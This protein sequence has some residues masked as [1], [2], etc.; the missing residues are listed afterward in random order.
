MARCGEF[1]LLLLLKRSLDPPAMLQPGDSELPG[2][3]QYGNVTSSC[4]RPFF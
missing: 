4:W 1:L 2:K 3:Q